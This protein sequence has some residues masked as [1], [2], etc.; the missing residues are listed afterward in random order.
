[1]TDHEVRTKRILDNLRNELTV[2]RL[3]DHEVRTKRILDNLRADLLAGDNELT[4][5]RLFVFL[6]SVYSPQY[7]R[8]RLDEATQ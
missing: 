2:F 8:E 4:M 6:A 1:M 7:L 3:T 5:F